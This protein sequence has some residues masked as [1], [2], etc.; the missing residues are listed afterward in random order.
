MKLPLI[1]R[2]IAPATRGVAAVEFALAA[3]LA[4][5]LLFGVI[6]IGFVMQAYSSLRSVAGTVSRYTVVQYMTGNQL[7]DNQIATVAV[8]QAIDNPYNLD[9]SQLD[10]T[11]VTDTVSGITGVKKINMTIDYVVPVIMPL[12]PRDSFNMQFEKSIYVY[13]P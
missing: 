8:A 4:L 5:L 6:Q 10:V 7:S 11:A 2:Q 1:V 9:G 12:I 3:P 13:A